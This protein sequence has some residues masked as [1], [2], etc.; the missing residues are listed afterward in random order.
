[1]VLF[2]IVFLIFVLISSINKSFKY[3]PE[4]YY[5]FSIIFISFIRLAS[6]IIF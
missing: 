6:K 5:L 4:L 1:M 2:W 3:L